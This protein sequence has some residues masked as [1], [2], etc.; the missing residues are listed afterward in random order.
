MCSSSVPGKRRSSKHRLI[1]TLFD[2]Q[3]GKCFYCRISC[4]II[5]KP[6]DNKWLPHRATVDH[7]RPKARGGG[8][9]NNLVMAC[10]KCNNLKA[11]KTMTEFLAPTFSHPMVYIPVQQERLSKTYM[12]LN[13]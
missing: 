11:D 13:A 9:K 1:H 7:K 8:S 12:Y 5:C 6:G 2:N 4:E 10:G 3:G